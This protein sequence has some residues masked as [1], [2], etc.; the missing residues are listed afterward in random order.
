ME[1][2][3]GTPGLEYGRYCTCVLY[4]GSK[5]LLTFYFPLPHLE[6]R[7]CF[8][9]FFSP[10]FVILFSVVVD[11]ILFVFS[12]PPTPSYIGGYCSTGPKLEDLYDEMDQLEKDPP[13][14]AS[15][16]IP[17][18]LREEEA[19]H[20]FENYSFD[21]TYS[22]DLPITIYRQQIVDTI[23]SNS[24]TVIQGTVPFT[25]NYYCYCF[26]CEHNNDTG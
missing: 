11:L 1:I 20:I 23:E 18:A 9:E 10:N 22:P 16:E 12:P 13:M 4:W 2:L 6:H 21:H 24:V 25:N 8:Y 5:G 19:T 15:D 17:A 26:M 7:K 3:I 14:G